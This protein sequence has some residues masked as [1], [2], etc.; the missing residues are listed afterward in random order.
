MKNLRGFAAVSMMTLFCC[1]IEMLPASAQKQVTATDRARVPSTVEESKVKFGAVRLLAANHVEI[2]EWKEAGSHSLSPST[3]FDVDCQI[4][5]T[6]V[7]YDDDFLVW[8]SIDFL[9]APASEEFAR[10]DSEQLG[11]EVSWEQITEMR[12]LKVVLV[13]HLTRGESR[14]VLLKEFDLSEVLE[15]FPT[16]DSDN[17]WPWLMRLNINAQDRSGKVVGS[18]YKIFALKP[19]PSR[20]S[21]SMKQ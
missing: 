12:D 3:Q 19:N 6:N 21:S 18:T 11:N 15:S 2:T 5:A 10:K 8:T 16:E 4:V 7:T 13:I 1:L 9:V 14:H 17:L 20:I